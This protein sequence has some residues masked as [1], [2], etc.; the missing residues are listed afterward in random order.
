MQS[1][2]NS[3]RSVSNDLFAL[4]RN[5]PGRRRFQLAFLLGLMLVSAAAEVFSLGAILPFLAI[6]IDPQQALR[7][8]MVANIATMFDSETTNDL[9]LGLAVTFAVAALT[10]GIVRFVL[11]YATASLTY[12][13][14]HEWAAEIYRRAL[15][16]RYEV[17]VT[18]NSSEVLGGLGK[19]D[20][21]VF[22]LL[23]VLS[24]VSSLLIAAFIV[25]ALILIDA[26]L[27]LF[28]LAGLG[29]VYTFV[30]LVTRKKLVKSSRIVNEALDKRIRAIQEGLGA[31]RDILLD[32]SQA[33]HLR[34]FSSVD[35]PLR[36]ALASIAIIGPSPRYAVEALGMM[37]IAGLAYTSVSSGDGLAIAIPAFGALVLGMQRLMPLI[38][39]VYIGCV[40]I[41][42]N[43]D[44]LRGVVLL[45]ETPIDEDISLSKERLPFER[46]IQFKGVCYRYQPN[47]PYVLKNFDLSIPKGSRVGVVGSTGS[48]KS[49]AMDLLMGLLQP[50]EGKI[51]VDGMAIEGNV[52]VAWQKNIAHVPQAIFLADASFSE[53]IAFGVPS[54]EIDRAQVMRA[55]NQ[56]QVA[57]IIEASENG[58]D[59]VVGERGV[60]LSGGQRQRIG[61]AR[62]LYKNAKVII[63]DE[64]TNALDSGTEASVIESIESLGRDITILMIAH[65][66][67]T[68]KGCDMIVEVSDGQI[69]RIATAEKYQAGDESPS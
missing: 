24:L 56:A 69:A 32:Q 23:S 68:L 20:Q 30:F 4:A 8:P 47:L 10:A 59:E 51:Y 44:V 26:K 35:W 43:Q 22:S 65:R 42:G 37:L 31:I 58:Y 49:T 3:E 64:A 54:E 50:T 53:N 46:D 13:I 55:A 34:R 2:G 39:Q 67:S 16:Q 29:G 12:G 45:L 25:M 66:V 7:M 1:R 62:A 60:R 19:V 61:I 14:G 63:F 21:I 52:R 18:R 15:Y 5:L 6:L 40:Q 11:N 38:Q 48:G 36:N 57:E 33:V 41:S 17:Q 28:V 27:T 9:R